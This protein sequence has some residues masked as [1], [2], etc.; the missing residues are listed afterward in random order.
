M[1]SN[2]LVLYHVAPSRSS[3]AHWMLEEIGQPFTLKV[4]NRKQ[5]ENR[6]AEYLSLNPA[7]KVPTLVH[8]GVAISETS[9]ICC[10]LADA[11]PAAGLSIPVGHK[12]RGVY[13]QWLFYGPSCLEPA[14]ID[15]KFPRAPIVGVEPAVVR[16]S[17]G[18]GDFETV[19][20]VLTQA[21]SKTP[22]LLG[23]QFTAA[24][25]II[26]G[27]L[28]WGMFVKALPE[29]KEFK[30]YVERVTNRPAWQRAHKK[31]MEL[32]NSNQ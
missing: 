1:A 32:M 31:D 28:R 29:T 26:G 3:Q 8:N 30:N 21:V 13:L 6:T 17:L 23:D 10:Y 24:D 25:L 16:G 19:M 12:L 15:Q 11:F 20:S 5:G 9:A 2:D 18:W 27:G 14:I 7:G 4:L 22:Y